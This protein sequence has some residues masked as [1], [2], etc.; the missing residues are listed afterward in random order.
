M[1]SEWRLSVNVGAH[2]FHLKRYCYLLLQKFWLQKTAI[3]ETCPVT[4]LSGVAIGSKS[5]L[6]SN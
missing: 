1:I 2:A 5:Q 6:E 4:D 3:G